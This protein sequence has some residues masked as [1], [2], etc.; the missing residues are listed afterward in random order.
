MTLAIGLVPLL[1]WHSLRHR[2]SLRRRYVADRRNFLRVA[3]L[4]VSGLVVWQASERL[5][6]LA[7]TP[8]R[9]GVSLVPTLRKV[10][11]SL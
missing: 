9:N 6:L 11:R 8:G 5:Q 7:G 10:L 3:L 1:L 4:G 2:I